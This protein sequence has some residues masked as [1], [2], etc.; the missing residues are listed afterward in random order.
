MKQLLFTILENTQL[1]ETVYKMRLSGDCTDFTRPGQFLNIR[2]DGLFLRRPIS[3]CDWT[4]DSVTILYK[5]VGTGTAR[6]LP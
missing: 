4:D 2:L 3:V 1:T 5:V 6:W